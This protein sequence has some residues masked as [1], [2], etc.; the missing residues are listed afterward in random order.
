MLCRTIEEATAYGISIVFFA[1]PSSDMTT[2][3]QESAE[4]TGRRIAKTSKKFYKK[5]TQG[6]GKVV[7]K[8]VELS[9]TG[10]DKSTGASKYQN[11]AIAINGRLER[12]LHVIEES[13][14]TKTVENELLTQQVAELRIE[15]TNL[16][17][18]LD[19][20]QAR[21]VIAPVSEHQVPPAQNP[22]KKYRWWQRPPSQS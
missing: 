5:T 6:V 2:E 18:Q 16:R 22:P 11:D 15:A 20:L 1:L 8:G 4:S 7:E 14:A 19:E 3:D 21:M 10:I 17:R 12:A 9:A 13:L